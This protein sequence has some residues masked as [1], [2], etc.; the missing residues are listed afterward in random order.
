MDKNM[1]RRDFLG[2]LGT[3]AAASA[4]LSPLAQGVLGREAQAVVV[5]E[6]VT[7]RGKIV[8]WPLVASGK[9]RLAL[10]GR[11]LTNSPLRKLRW[12]V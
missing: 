9:I 12:H 1:N 3:A 8:T 5:G 6:K 7:P 10:D 2:T 11:A 4:A